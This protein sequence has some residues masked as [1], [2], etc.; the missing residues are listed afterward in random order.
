G[1]NGTKIV[2]MLT[3]G[4]DVQEEAIEFQQKWN[5]LTDAQVMGVETANDAMARLHTA[6]Q[7]FA[8]ML[9]A[10]MAPLFEIMA[11]DTLAMADS[12]ERMD[13]FTKGMAESIAMGAGDLQDYWELFSLLSDLPSKTWKL[14]FSGAADVLDRAFTFDKGPQKYMELLQR[15]VQ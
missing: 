11:K 9:A 7:G 8:N 1:K 6:G 12:L 3:S 2:A 15:R 10:D 5:G 13:S 14:D 4:R